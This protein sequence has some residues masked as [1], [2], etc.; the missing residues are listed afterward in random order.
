MEY[1]VPTANAILARAHENKMMRCLDFRSRAIIRFVQ[2]GYRLNELGVKKREYNK[3]LQRIGVAAGHTR[4]VGDV[5]K[6][7]R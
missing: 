6:S 1:T 2:H 5:E 7:S 4:S 3:I